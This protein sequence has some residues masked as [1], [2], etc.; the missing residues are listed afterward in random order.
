[1]LYTCNGILLSHKKDWINSVCSNIDGPRN[2]HIKWS[3]SDKDKYYIS[4]IY[5][6]FKNGTN[7]LIYEMEKTRRPQI[8]TYGYQRG[9]VGGEGIN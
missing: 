3:K 1:M 8:Q 5:G 2:Y 9:K 6:I 7:E 4:L